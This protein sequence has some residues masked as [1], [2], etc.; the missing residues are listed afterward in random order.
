[1]SCYHC[2]KK[3]DKEDLDTPRCNAY[4][5]VYYCSEKCKFP[6]DDYVLCD[7]LSVEDR[8]RYC[9]KCIENQV[10][11]HGK[12]RCINCAYNAKSYICDKCYL[13]L[14]GIFIPPEKV[15]PTEKSS[16]EDTRNTSKSL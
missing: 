14:K 1:M 11:L 13:K 8:D 9:G 2:K 12:L 6:R 15:T 10:G 16:E 3:V 4:C 5:F 7:C